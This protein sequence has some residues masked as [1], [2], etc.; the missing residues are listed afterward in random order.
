MSQ[1]PRI[2]IQLD[3]DTHPSVFD[4]V[5]AIDSAVDHLLQ[6]GS[7]APSHVRSLVHGAMFTRGPD[8]LKNT[9]VFIGGSNAATGDAIAQA[10]RAT[11]F[12]PV[13][14]SVMLDGNGSNTTA[15]AA[16]LCAR[17]HLELSTANALVVGGTGPVGQRVA[18]LLLGQ[19]ATVAISSRDRMRAEKSGEDLLKYVPESFHSNLSALS[20]EDDSN[21]D[22]ALQG[23]NL[24]I[25]CGAAGVRLVT[26]Q[27]LAKA[28]ELQVA[29]DLNAVAPEGI[30][31][32]SVMDKAV[33]RGT[34]VDYGAIGT[35]GLKM[36]I[37]RE[38]VQ[39]LFS[40]NDLFL[41]AEQIY[42]I[43]LNLEKAREV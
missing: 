23:R 7:V 43:G 3:S 2:L 41:D 21:M 33:S 27:S 31:G 26:A 28:R 30:E 35:G 10:V 5:V 16:V 39:T 22:A 34:R 37:H 42:E 15:A 38:A 11:F 24:L 6:Y 9:A 1:H 13:S 29:I 12:G 32:L 25:C 17:R 19:G 40:R 8:V 36:K 18:R 4:S 20:I 14:V